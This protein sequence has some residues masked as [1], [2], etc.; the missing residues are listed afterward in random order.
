MVR[1]WEWEETKGRDRDLFRLFLDAFRIALIS[2]LGVSVQKPAIMQFWERPE[3]AQNWSDFDL[4]KSHRKNSTLFRKYWSWDTM[5]CKQK[6]IVL[7]GNYSTDPNNVSSEVKSH[8]FS[9]GIG[10]C[11]F[12]TFPRNCTICTHT[13]TNA[14]VQNICVDERFWWHL[15]LWVVWEVPM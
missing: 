9:I 3:K 6:I 14:S 1:K 10:Q 13:H 8:I 5:F 15:H 12:A 11:T 2:I 4:S 7:H